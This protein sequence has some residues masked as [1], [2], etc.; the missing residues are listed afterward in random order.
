MRLREPL[1]V[2]LLDAIEALRGKPVTEHH[3]Q[4]WDK[5]LGLGGIHSYKDQAKPSQASQPAYA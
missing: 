5:T 4:D 2:A 3:E 1:W